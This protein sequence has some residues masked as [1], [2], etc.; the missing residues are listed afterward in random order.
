MSCLIRSRLESTIAAGQDF[1]QRLSNLSPQVHVNVLYKHLLSTKVSGIATL[2]EEPTAP[3]LFDAF[4]A[5]TPQE[6]VTNLQAFIDAQILM[7]DS[8]HRLAM[9]VTCLPERHET[10]SDQS[11]SLSQA[12]VEH[13][14]IYPAESHEMILD[15]CLRLLNERLR[16]DVCDIRD[17]G[18]ANEDVPDLF[19][20]IARSMPKAV[21]YACECWPVHFLASGN[22]SGTVFSALVEFCTDHLLHWLEVLSLLGKLSSAQEHLPRMLLWCQVSVSLDIQRYLNATRR[23]IMRYLLLSRRFQHS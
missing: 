7:N 9:N 3:V 13:Y 15:C 12:Q 19:A 17:P 23:I 20:R 6:T 2:L 5:L 18:L 4:L 10:L 16:Q 22:V 8:L 21:R 1:I 11:P 14:L